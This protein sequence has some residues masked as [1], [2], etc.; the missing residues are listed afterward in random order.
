MTAIPILRARH[1]IGA[2]LSATLLCTLFF[3]Y[4]AGAE[5]TKD[6][7]T[8]AVLTDFPPL[9]T[10]NSTGEPDGF[11]LDVL[12]AVSAETKIT[13]DL[14]VVQNW[15]EALEAVSSGRADF[16]PGIGITEPNKQKFIY[17]DVMETVSI[18]CFVRSESTDIK[19]ISDLAGHRVAFIE[20]TAPQAMLSTRPDVILMPLSSIDEALFSLL[21]GKSDAIIFPESFLWRTARKIGVD[22]RIKVVGPPLMEVKRGYLLRKDNTELRDRLNKALNSY[23][24]SPAFNK[25]YLKWRGSPTPYWTIHKVASAGL[26]LLVVIVIEFSL[27]R[28]RSVSKLNKRL[29]QSIADQARTQAL[30]KASESQLNRAQE[31]SSLGSLERN[32]ITDVGH[33][34]AGLYKV[35][36]FPQTK[37]APSTEEFRQ[38][39]HPDDLKEYRRKANAVSPEA[40]S[41]FIEFRFRQPGKGTYRTAAGVF[42]YEFADDGTPIKRIGAIQD[43]TRQ[44]QIEA[45]LIEAKENAE[46]ANTSKSEFLANMSHE[47][48]TPLNGI[49]GMLQLIVLEDI[50]TTHKEY[51]ETALSSCKNLARLIGDILDL[52]KVEAGKMELRPVPFSPNELVSSVRD[53]FVQQ[54]KEKD[55]TL[56]LTVVDDIPECVIGDSARLRQ[57]LF[58]LIGNAIKFTEQ[59]SISLQ[60]SKLYSKSSEAHRLLFS[61]TDT[62]I[63][64]PQDMLEKVFGAF[65]QVKGTSRKFQG[66]G[67]GLHIVKQLATLM[68][69]EVS[70][71]SSE[72]KGTTVNFSA[73]FKWDDRSEAQCH[74]PIEIHE[75]SIPPQHILIVE[76]ERVN[77][78]AITKLVERLGHTTVKANNG[79][80][81]LE[82][83]E[84]EDFDLILMDIQMPIMDGIE[85]TGRIRSLKDKQK[86]NIPIIALTAHAMSGDREKFLEV[87]MNDYLAK[88]VS[89]DGLNNILGKVLSA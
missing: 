51:V 73:V 23:V 6:H 70:I 84:E 5:H 12:K 25:V 66:T 10:T 69:G 42:S 9:Y 74:A 24:A 38:C 2:I 18:S 4:P 78:I 50:D 85:A 43:I 1:L 54:A 58:N 13:Y 49:M 64:I 15:A 33:W 60:V 22:N 82:K 62:G 19:N 77:Q 86:R 45:Q 71:E 17:T 53:A 47:L 87:G 88:P 44:K 36:G 35:L 29:K 8:A 27:W 76:D 41:F 75:E 16:I 48:R 80:M 39:F 40:P 30:L 52:S 65:T 72:D 20:K 63:G 46:A 68:G 32:L 79:K 59:G 34:S 81:A 21:S 3:A 11:A 55:L 89:L 31:L 28:W 57:V 83:L 56:S 26:I 14:L 37:E 67:L 61:V 7:F